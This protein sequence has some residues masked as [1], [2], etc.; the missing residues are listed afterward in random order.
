[1]KKVTIHLGADCLC[2]EAG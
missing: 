1:M 2:P